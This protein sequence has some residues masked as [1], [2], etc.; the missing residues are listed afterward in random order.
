MAKISGPHTVGW[1]VYAS[2]RNME[3]LLTRRSAFLVDRTL[4]QR[5]VLLMRL[6]APITVLHR[7]IRNT[8]IFVRL[9]PPDRRGSP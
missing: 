5:S 1:Q 7:M 4:S 2:A 8:Q 6:R 9:P 3:A